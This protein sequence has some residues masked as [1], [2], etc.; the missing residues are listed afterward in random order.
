MMLRSFMLSLLIIFTL[1][2]HAQDRGPIVRLDPTLDN[3]VPPGAQ[4]EK[5]A[6][7][8]RSNEGPV[9]AREGGYLLFSDTPANVI[10]KWDPATKKVSVFLDH[11]SKGDAVSG[12]NGITLD[13]QGRVVYVAVGDQAIVRLEKDGTRTVLASQ[14]EGKPFS[15][16]NDLV[17]KSNGSLYFTDPG[18]RDSA[19]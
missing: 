3:I 10:D 6:G 14:Y 8:F 7:D 1:N 18:R 4:V 15:R 12:S 17:Y 9:W 2:G 16:P 13:R 19:G 5:L 11:P